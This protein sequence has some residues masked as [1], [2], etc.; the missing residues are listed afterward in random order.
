[1]PSPIGSVRQ[2]ETLLRDG[3]TFYKPVVLFI[4]EIQNIRRDTAASHLL[5]H[6]QTQSIA[7]VIVVCAGL[8][9]AESRLIDAGISRPVA[10]NIYSLGTLSPDESLVATRESLQVIANV[11]VKGGQD[12]AKIFPGGGPR[13]TNYC[14]SVSSH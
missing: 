4:H 6:L 10:E 7:P 13:W 5:R 2:I 8:S 3:Q 12:F 14:A 1:M 11:G 9:S